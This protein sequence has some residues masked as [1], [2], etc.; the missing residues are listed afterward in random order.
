MLKPFLIA[1]G[2]PEFPRTQPRERERLRAEGTLE[3]NILQQC[4]AGG[5]G[6]C[7]CWAQMLLLFTC[8]WIRW[9]GSD[10]SAEVQP[11][12]R[13]G[14]TQEGEALPPTGGLKVKGMLENMRALTVYCIVGFSTSEWV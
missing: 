3:G 13:G 14:N 12:Y 10:L 6:C 11:S 9:A 1:A 8:G 5:W 4:C 2:L 7:S